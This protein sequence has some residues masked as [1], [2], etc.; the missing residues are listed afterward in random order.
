MQVEQ[1]L[2]NPFSSGEV[3]IRGSQGLGLSTAGRSGWVSLD[4]SLFRG[5]N[6]WAGR[7]GR[8]IGTFSSAKTS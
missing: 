1:V 5:E 8:G 6:R 2:F 3:E 7:E 4:L